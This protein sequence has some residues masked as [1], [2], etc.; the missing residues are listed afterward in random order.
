MSRV[1]PTLWFSLFSGPAA[2]LVGVAYPGA[3]PLA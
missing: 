1:L 3:L 2:M